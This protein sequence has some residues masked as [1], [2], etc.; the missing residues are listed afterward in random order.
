MQQEKYAFSKRM[1]DLANV[2]LVG[3]DKITMICVYIKINYTCL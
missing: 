3:R 2:L 1:V